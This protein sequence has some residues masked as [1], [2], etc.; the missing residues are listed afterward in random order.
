MSPLN[1]EHFLRVLKNYSSSSL[2]DAEN[3]LLLKDNFPFSQILHTLSARVSKDH[4]FKNNQHLLQIS[5]V[6]ATDRSILKEIMSAEADEQV[7]VAITA[8][9]K[10]LSNQEIDNDGVAEELIHD[11]AKLTELRNNFEMLFIDDTTVSEK[12]SVSANLTSDNSEKEHKSKKE[13]IIELAKSLNTPDVTS[14]KEET[15]AVRL[16]RRKRQNADIIDEIAITKEE[17]VVETEKQKEQIL[18][19]EK[20]IKIQPSISSAK[21]KSPE[22][23]DLATIKTGEFT[24]NIVSETLVEILLK[25]G[26]K[27]KAVEVLKKLIWKFPQKKAYFAAQ[28]EELKK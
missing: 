7:S 8:E 27:D 3:V 16:Q 21:E 17:L 26:K 6:Y 4:N 5:A 22:Q 25:Q 23:N 12:L 24:D 2:Q 20:F 10:E 18:I 14:P 15:F 13:R 11:L 19:I 1:K 9:A 28:I